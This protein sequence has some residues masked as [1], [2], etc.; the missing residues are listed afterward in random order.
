MPCTEPLRNSGQQ[1]SATALAWGGHHRNGRAVF[2]GA[3]LALR[4][5]SCKPIRRDVAADLEI[6][7]IG[8]SLRPSSTA[9][10]RRFS[11]LC[12]G[13]V[14]RRSGARR[15]ARR[16][17]QRRCD[18]KGQGIETAVR[19]AAIGPLCL[20]CCAT[21]QSLR[22]CPT[23]SVG[24]HPG[25]LDCSNC[26]CRDLPVGPTGLRRVPAAPGRRVHVSRAFRMMVWW[27]AGVH[28]GPIEARTRG[29]YG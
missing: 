19:L 4:R 28:G 22:A 24:G 13:M 11:A 3:A 21:A 2:V 14:H 17:S 5:P 20:P 8:P 23:D 29:Q 12:F 9:C 10:S 1:A 6:R 7:P 25:P 26:R 18:G 16:V 15:C 27:A